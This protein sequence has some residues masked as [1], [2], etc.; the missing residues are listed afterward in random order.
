[1]A[2]SS[3]LSACNFH[4]FKVILK[5]ATNQRMQ[6]LEL[7]MNTGC[8]LRIVTRISKKTLEIETLKYEESEYAPTSCFSG[9]IIFQTFVFC[10]SYLSYDAMKLTYS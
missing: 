5:S 3:Q 4:V 1:M 6:R 8:T 9:P 2:A 10:Q 7:Q